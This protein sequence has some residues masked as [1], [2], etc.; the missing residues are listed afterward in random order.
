MQDV[1]G[2]VGHYSF[3]DEPLVDMH[4]NPAF[5]AM[6]ERIDRLGGYG[7]ET[8][9]FIGDYVGL[10]MIGSLL[11][12]SIYNAASARM[13]QRIRFAGN[14][15]YNFLEKPLENIL[16]AA[17]PVAA[18]R[19]ATAAYNGYQRLGL[20]SRQITPELISSQTLMLGELISEPTLISDAEFLR[21][22]IS[23][24]P[25]KFTHPIARAED[26]YRYGYNNI[27][28]SKINDI[29]TAKMAIETLSYDM[30]FGWISDLLL[31]QTSRS[32]CSIFLPKGKWSPEG[33]SGIWSPF[34][35]LRGQ[36]VETPWGKNGY[37]RIPN[38]SISLYVD[39]RDLEIIKTTLAHEGAHHAAH[40]F[41]EDLWAN[42]FTTQAQ[43]YKFNCSI[44][45]DA[46]LSVPITGIKDIIPGS[47]ADYLFRKPREYFNNVF[48]K[49]FSSQEWGISFDQLESILTQAELAFYR[50]ESELDLIVKSFERFNISPKKAKD[51]YLLASAS[52]SAEYPAYYVT[53]IEKFGGEALIKEIIP[54]TIP[55]YE[56]AFSDIYHY[57]D[58]NG[59]LLT[60]SEKKTFQQF[61]L[62][63]KKSAPTEL[64]VTPVKVTPV[65]DDQFLRGSI[66]S[67]TLP[68]TVRSR[69]KAVKL[70]IEGRIRFIPPE[71][72]NPS[73]PLG[74]GPHG[75]YIDRFNN[76]WQKGASRTPD[77]PF[78]WDVQLS[79]LGQK[80]LGWISPGRD[81][82]NVSID[83]RI[84][85]R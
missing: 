38:P 2:V 31:A 5:P 65:S 9:S 24:Q 17:M 4:D 61:G 37:T 69:L 53:A 79:P 78:E 21:G 12:T 46:N 30:K 34:E 13:D 1:G 84:S 54:N 64:S 19:Y 74:R 82:V 68:W 41:S 56:Q 57:L 42:P 55:I 23:F 36:F 60:K 6:S 62:F 58:R 8:A 48:K 80:Q 70:P 77:H 7:Y 27:Y 28:A 72:Y 75:G 3:G 15:L 26:I 35:R 10:A 29:V 50:G 45:K 44:I 33:F 25:Y 32:E 59:Y 47:P 51:A 40:L 14:L 76:E 11:P 22:N 20:F 81:Y 63:D 16:R 52:R 39:G 18:V 43:Q 71:D 49:C 73:N 67:L 66:D 85:H 83:G